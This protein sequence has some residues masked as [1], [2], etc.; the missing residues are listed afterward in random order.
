MEFVGIAV[1]P[2]KHRKVHA[3]RTAELSTQEHMPGLRGLQWSL[4]CF[5]AYL[6]RMNSFSNPEEHTMKS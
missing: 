2:E 4:G 5:G 1:L 3:C 6:C